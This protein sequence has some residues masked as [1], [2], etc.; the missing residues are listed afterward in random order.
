RYAIRISASFNGDT[1][2]TSNFAVGLREEALGGPSLLH[3]HCNLNFHWYT[4]GDINAAELE[5]RCLTAGATNIALGEKLVLVDNLT[6]AGATI[7][8]E[9]TWEMQTA[10]STV[11]GGMVICGMTRTGS[12][13]TAAVK[14]VAE[15]QRI[16]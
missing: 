4:Y 5:S 11:W 7:I 3:A 8:A 10:A 13:S 15:C 1:S 14:L 16:A 2:E 12:A 9:G 6:L